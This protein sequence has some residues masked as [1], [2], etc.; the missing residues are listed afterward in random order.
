MGNYLTSPFSFDELN[1]NNDQLI[2]FLGQPLKGLVIL[3]FRY[4]WLKP[5][6]IHGQRLR[7]FHSN[8]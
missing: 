6:V 8:S 5:A 2:L 7:R 4:R 1:L 3:L